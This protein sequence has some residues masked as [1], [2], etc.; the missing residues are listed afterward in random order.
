MNKSAEGVR[1]DR[2]AGIGDVRARLPVAFGALLPAVSLGLA[3]CC[4]VTLAA[5]PAETSKQPAATST[6]A[7]QTQ[8]DAAAQEKPDAVAEERKDGKDTAGKKASPQ[9]FV[10]SEQVRADFDVSFPVDI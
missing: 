3:L 4:G 9:R 1:K 2:A 10:P 7:P 5:E 6:P 8:A